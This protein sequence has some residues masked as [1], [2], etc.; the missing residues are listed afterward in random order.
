MRSSMDYIDMKIS[1]IPF[2]SC[3]LHWLT[4]MTHCVSSSALRE[5]DDAES[6]SIIARSEAVVVSSV[7]SRPREAA[8]AAAAPRAWAA[9][10]RIF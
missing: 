9:A 3:A 5:A 10:L 2:Y 1:S 7:V 4:H 6:S 8:F